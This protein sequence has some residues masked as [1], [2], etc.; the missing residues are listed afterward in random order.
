MSAPKHGCS[1]EVV[2]RN[3]NRVAT[4]WLG[5]CTCKQR[6][7]GASY[8]ETEDKWRQHVHAETGKV[9]RPCGSQADRWSA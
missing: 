8:E 1:F 9:P 6:W 2:E 4:S 7:T 3:A 5:T